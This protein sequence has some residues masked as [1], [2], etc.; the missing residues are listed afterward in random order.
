M[1]EAKQPQNK[2]FSEAIRYTFDDT[3]LEDENPVISIFN[4]LSQL[5]MEVRKLESL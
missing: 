1:E 5:K 2:E 3:L 4:L